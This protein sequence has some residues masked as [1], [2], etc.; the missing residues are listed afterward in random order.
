MAHKAG[1]IGLGVVGR[2]TL[3][4][5]AAHD[6]FEVAAAWDIDPGARAAAARDVPGLAIAA[7]A[8][9]VI[10]SP[11]EVIYIATPP[12]HHHDYVVA[13]LA[14]G[15]AIFCEKPLGID[16]GQSRALTDRVEAS[17]LESAVN[18]VYGSAP[19]AVALGRAVEAGEL[20]A[21]EGIDIRLHFASWPR[22]WQEGAAWLKGSEQGGFGREVLSH[23]VFLANRL[24][25]PASIEGARVRYPGGGGAESA[26]AALLDCGGVQLTVAGSVGGQG[27]DRVECTLWGAAAS[28]RITDWYRLWRSDGGEW[29]EQLTEL[30]DPREAA[31]R[32]QLDNLAA[33][34]DGGAHTMPSFREALA[35]QETIETLLRQGENTP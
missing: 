9:A 23:F 19:A 16:V 30:A 21:I 11:A 7:D 34:L 31:Y 14:A 17:G 12:L 32:G 18:F 25:G 24:L 29:A 1:I 22:G 2:R 20:G 15:K 28:Y 4:N 6:G 5:L 35:V 27:P 10:G 8:A 33:M 26:I 3:A 13:T